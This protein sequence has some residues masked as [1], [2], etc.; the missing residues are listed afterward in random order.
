MQ[1]SWCSWFM[2]G[3]IPYLTPCL[4][5][6]QVILNTDTVLHNLQSS[7]HYIERHQR[8]FAT[9]GLHK[10]AFS[11]H[12]DWRRPPCPAETKIQVSFICYKNTKRNPN[13]SWIS[14]HTMVLKDIIRLSTKNGYPSNWHIIQMTSRSLMLGGT[15]AS[16]GSLSFLFGGKTRPPERTFILSL[17]FPVI[18][19]KT[20]HFR[21]N[22]K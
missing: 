4:F 6:F 12:C 7:H 3:L 11:I 22:Q 10:T 14:Q 2:H 15:L 13:N 17:F 1:V 9:K 8:P 19:K 18:C 16:H 20:I 5:L 21:S